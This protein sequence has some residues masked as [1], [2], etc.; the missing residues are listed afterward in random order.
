MT[1][2]GVN[3]NARSCV[4]PFQPSI[5]AACAPMNRMPRVNDAFQV[6]FEL[7]PFVTVDAKDF[8]YGA[9][10]LVGASITVGD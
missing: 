7:G 1:C 10:V 4:V 3:G 5:L 8:T 2:R 9:Y 6:V